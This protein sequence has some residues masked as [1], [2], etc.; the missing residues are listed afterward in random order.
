MTATRSHITRFSTPVIVAANT[1]ESTTAE[2]DYR[3]YAGGSFNVPSGSSITSVT[4]YAKSGCLGDVH[5]P[6]QDSAGAAVTQTVAADKGYPIPI[7]LFG[8]AYIKPV[9]NASGTLYFDFKG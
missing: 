3:G 6:A 7:A 2:I 5:K 1:A 4:W 9:V 8:R